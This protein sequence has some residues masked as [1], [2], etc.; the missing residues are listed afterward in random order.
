M[1]FFSYAQFHVFVR[2]LLTTILVMNRK[3]AIEALVFPLSST[4][5]YLCRF[6]I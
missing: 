2:I 4:V 5:A 6:V 1:L 3:F